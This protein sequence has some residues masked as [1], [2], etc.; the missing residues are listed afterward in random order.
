MYTYTYLRRIVI[1]LLLYIVVLFG[2][3]I[4]H[5]NNNNNNNGRDV[6]LRSDEVWCGAPGVIY[7]LLLKR[8]TAHV[9]DML[10]YV[11]NVKPSGGKKDTHIR[12][13][14]KK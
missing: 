10:R 6:L 8:Q 7:I 14:F 3:R 1:I 13:D 11:S 4:V 12:F 9:Y 5:N 2:V